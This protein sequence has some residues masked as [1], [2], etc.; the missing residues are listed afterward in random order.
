MC[1]SSTMFVVVLCSGILTLVISYV[2]KGKH[3]EENE[4]K[5]QQALGLSRNTL[6]SDILN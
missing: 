6:A 5:S 3:A 2:R 1:T 4:V